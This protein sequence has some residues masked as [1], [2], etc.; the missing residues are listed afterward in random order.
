MVRVITLLA[1]L[2][3]L[4]LPTGAGAKSRSSG[5][6]PLITL[7]DGRHWASSRS[8]RRPVTEPQR[9]ATTLPRTGGEPGLAALAGLGLMLVGGGVRMRHA[10]FRAGAV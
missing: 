3:M 10:R 5:S 9:G 8:H 6:R 4:V 7:R 2:A 1:V